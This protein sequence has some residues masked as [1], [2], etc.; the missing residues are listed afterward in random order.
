MESNALALGK[1]ESK[2]LALGK[3]ESKA[4]ALGKMESKA[5]SRYQPLVQCQLLP[6]IFLLS[7]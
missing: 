5:F 4:L 7:I 2:A 6:V 1:M 3:M